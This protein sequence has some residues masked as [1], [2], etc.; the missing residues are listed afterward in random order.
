[1]HPQLE[2]LLRSFRHVLVPELN[3]GQLS[4]LLRARYLIDAKGVNKVQGLPFKVQEIVDAVLQTLEG[5]PVELASAMT[6]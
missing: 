4:L 6:A 2:T 5:K 3:M 1:M